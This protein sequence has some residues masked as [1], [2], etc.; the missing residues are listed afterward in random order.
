MLTMRSTGATDAAGRGPARVEIAPSRPCVRTKAEI[1]CGW[2]LNRSICG[3]ADHGEVAHRREASILQSVVVGHGSEHRDQLVKATDELCSFLAFEVILRL[4]PRRRNGV[5]LREWILVIAVTVLEV[6]LRS[7]RLQAKTRE[8]LGRWTSGIPTSAARTGGR[9]GR[10]VVEQIRV[11]F[12]A[13]RFDVAV[14]RSWLRRETSQVT[15]MKQ[16]RLKSGSRQL[17]RC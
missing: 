15:W 11:V 3:S 4:E 9:S 1:S 7:S 12:V 6:A 17:S 2:A 13:R 14:D 10:C 5:E 16:S 8:T